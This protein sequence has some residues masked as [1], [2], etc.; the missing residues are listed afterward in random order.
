MKNL[1]LILL[2]FLCIQ[3][4]SQEKPKEIKTVTFK[5]AGNCEQCKNRIE[6][7]CDL[8]GVKLAEWDTKTQLLKVTYRTD[9]ATEEQIKQAVLSS[10]HDIENLK[11]PDAAYQKLPDCC[12]FRDKKCAK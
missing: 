1:F 11:A 5:V 8:K 2:S 12:K 10:G 9:K 4:Y 3:S 6:N 7:A